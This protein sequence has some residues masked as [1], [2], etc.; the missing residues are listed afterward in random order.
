MSKG[1]YIVCFGGGWCVANY[2]GRNFWYD[3]SPIDKFWNVSV[4]KQIIKF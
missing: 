2:D 1:L 3:G 4:G